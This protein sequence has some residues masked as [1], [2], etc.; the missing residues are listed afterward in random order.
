MAIDRDTTRLSFFRDLNQKCKS[1]AINF[2]E[3]KMPLIVIYEKP[4]DFPDKYVARKW[5]LNRATK[6]AVIRVTWD[7]IIQVVPGNFFMKH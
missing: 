2:E 5:N 4:T 3:Y 7:E 6:L 1:L